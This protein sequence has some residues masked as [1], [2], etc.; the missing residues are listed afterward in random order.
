MRALVVD[1]SQVIRAML[2]AD[3]G[4]R[5]LAVDEASGGRSALEKARAKRY[6]IIVTDQNMPGME[7]LDLVKS[8]RG[9][10][11]YEKTPI[12]V[13]T[14]ETSDEMKTKFRQAGASGWM[15][16]PYSPERMTNALAKI[17]PDA[18]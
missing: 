6:D 7:G 12:L 18:V 5:G 15:S 13:L 16:K 8:L 17:L 2:V 4:Q 9:M 1:D 14:T 3:L 10:P 11:G